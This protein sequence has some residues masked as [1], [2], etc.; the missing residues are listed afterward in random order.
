[1]VQ[2]YV[3]RRQKPRVAEQCD[4]NIHSL[5]HFTVC[6]HTFN[7]STPYRRIHLLTGQA[8][9]ERKPVFR[10]KVHFIVAGPISNIISA[11]S[12]EILLQSQKQEK[13]TWCEIRT[14]GW[15]KRSQPRVAIWF[16]IDVAENL[17][18]LPG[19]PSGQGN[20]LVVVRVKSS[21]L[22]PPKT[23]RVKE[24]ASLKDYRGSN[25]H[26]LGSHNHIQVKAVKST[27]S[28][29]L[30][31]P[32]VQYHCKESNMP[33][34]FQYYTV[35]QCPKSRY[36][37]P[38]VENRPSPKLLS[39]FPMHPLLILHR[40]FPPCLVILNLRLKGLRL[41]DISNILAAVPTELKK[42]SGYGH[43]FMTNMSRVLVL[44]ALKIHRAKGEE[45]GK[46]FE[47]DIAKQFFV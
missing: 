44:V 11:P 18:I 28:V 17:F 39:C 45:A 30:F 21:K 32:Q 10:P 47:R 12:D 31:L 7:S 40:C 22:V 16:C 13:V 43:E 29:K 8:F 42:L 34:V 27:F 19:L 41:S 37:Q 5:I 20:G 24:P 23:R 38:I 35:N 25:V 15:C 1:M 6:K 14:G 3:V 4:V 2:N 46:E 26:P 33:L 9:K 36:M